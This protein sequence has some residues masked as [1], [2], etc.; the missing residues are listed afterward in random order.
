MSFFFILLRLLLFVSSIFS[1]SPLHFCFFVTTTLYGSFSKVSIAY[2]I[3]FS[4]RFSFFFSFS[5]LFILH[6]L[7]TQLLLRCFTTT[8]RAER[9]PLIVLQFFSITITCIKRRQFK[10]IKSCICFLSP[11]HLQD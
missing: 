5:A 7:F 6:I 9:I 8:D 3:S 4:C 11:F 1:P 2:N 10:N